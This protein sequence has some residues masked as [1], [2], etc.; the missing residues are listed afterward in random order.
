MNQVC[1]LFGISKRTYYRISI[2][3]ETFQQ[4]YIHVKQF[5]EQLIKA[6]PGYGIRRLKQSLYDEFELVIG[7][8]VLAKLLKEWQLSLKRKIKRSRPSMIQKLLVWLGGKANLLNRMTLESPLQAITSDITRLY[9]DQGNAYCYLCVHK[10]AYG[11]VVYGHDISR[12][13]E[14][15]LVLNSFA[16]AIRSIQ[17]LVPNRLDRKPKLIVHQDQGSQYTSYEYVDAVLKAG[18]QL[19]YSRKSQPIDNAGQESFFGRFKDDWGDEI[20][21]LSSF[22]EVTVFVKDKLKYYNER[23][24]HT[25]ADMKSPMTFTKICLNFLGNRFT[26]LRT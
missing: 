4:K 23:R 15:Q 18:C 21:E 6:H 20:L 14:L 13:M 1:H 22:E 17:R 10:D 24:L 25:K 5:L 2:S 16:Q 26:K 3:G 9:Y 7:R 12:R 8:D 11:Q 19:S